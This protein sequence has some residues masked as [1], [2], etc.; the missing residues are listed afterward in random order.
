MIKESD[1]N[2][3]ASTV[4]TN[5][6]NPFGNALI[7]PVVSEEKVMI[8]LADVTMN[9]EKSVPSHFV[10]KLLLDG[11]DQKDARCIQGFQRKKIIKI[12]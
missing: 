3:P 1:V 9:F 8:V 7:K 4:I 11:T 5:K 10:G 6:W 12:K 2:G